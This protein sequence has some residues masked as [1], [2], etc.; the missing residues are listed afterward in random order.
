MVSCCSRYL[1]NQ[2]KCI[3]KLIKV[4]FWKQAIILGVTNGPEKRANTETLDE[5]KK[6]NANEKKSFICSVANKVFGN[7]KWRR[8][9]NELLGSVL[10]SYIVVLFHGHSWYE[11]FQKFE[12]KRTIKPHLHAKKTSTAYHIFG[13]GIVS[14]TDLPFHTTINDNVFVAWEWC[15]LFI[16]TPFIPFV[17][18]LVRKWRNKSNLWFF[19]VSSKRAVHRHQLKNEVHRHIKKWRNEKKK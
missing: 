9:R 1:G 3:V 4:L 12:S 6:T 16:G 10:I 18:L 13:T 2:G 17:S 19:T 11:H 14:G 8:K 15:Q 7:R 5:K